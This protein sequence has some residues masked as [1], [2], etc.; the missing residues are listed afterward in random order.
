M[1]RQVRAERVCDAGGVVFVPLDRQLGTASVLPAKEPPRHCEESP[2]RSGLCAGASGLRRPPIARRRSARPGSKRP[3][4]NESRLRMSPP[5]DHPIHPH[6]RHCSF[7]SVAQRLR[8]VIDAPWAAALCHRQWLHFTPPPIFLR[9]AKLPISP[10]LRL[11][12]SGPMLV[13]NSSFTQILKYRIPGLT[14]IWS[15]EYCWQ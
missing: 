14:S 12:G 15:S 3:P 6:L 8:I 13:Q 11:R 4:T 2:A 1:H 10:R 9:L 5:T 7:E